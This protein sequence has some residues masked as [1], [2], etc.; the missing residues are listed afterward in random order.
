V[1]REALRGPVRILGD[2]E[3]YWDCT[4]GV[5]DIMGNKERDWAMTVF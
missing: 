3:R 1:H 2:M 4:E 5:R